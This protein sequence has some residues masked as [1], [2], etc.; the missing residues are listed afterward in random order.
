LKSVLRDLGVGTFGTEKQGGEHKTSEVESPLINR[1]QDE[2]RRERIRNYIVILALLAV[3]A[4][5]FLKQF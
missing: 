1:H 3:I 2:R 4:F 5:L